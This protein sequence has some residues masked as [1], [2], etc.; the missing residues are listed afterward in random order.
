[1][2]PG[3]VLSDIRLVADI[4]NLHFDESEDRVCLVTTS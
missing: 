1:M 4:H 2:N 3:I